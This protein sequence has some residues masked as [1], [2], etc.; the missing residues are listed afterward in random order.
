M[1]E[2]A[3]HYFVWSKTESQ[4]AAFSAGTSLGALAPEVTEQSRSDGDARLELDAIVEDVWKDS[5]N[6]S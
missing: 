3:R 5:E 1:H 4:P 6:E 2:V